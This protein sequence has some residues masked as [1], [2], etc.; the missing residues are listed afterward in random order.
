MLT[1]GDPSPS[2]AALLDSSTREE[3]LFVPHGES[4]IRYPQVDAPAVASLPEQMDT[5]LVP[6]TVGLQCAPLQVVRKEEQ[7]RFALV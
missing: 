6:H 1:P 4:L 5:A 7:K 2:V 3:K